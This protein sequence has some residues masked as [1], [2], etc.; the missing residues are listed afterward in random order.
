MELF[1]LIERFKRKITFLEKQKLHKQMTFFL[2]EENSQKYQ[3]ARAR[4]ET[5][6]EDVDDNLKKMAFH[7]MNPDQEKY[8]EAVRTTYYDEN[9]DIEERVSLAKAEEILEFYKRECIRAEIE[10]AG[11][12]AAQKEYVEQVKDHIFIDFN[13]DVQDAFLAFQHYGLNPNITEED[14]KVYREIVAKTHNINDS[15]YN[16]RGSAKKTGRKSVV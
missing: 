11:D 12:E 3:E 10:Y 16:S 13:E 6:E 15:N 9:E 4:I 7:I 8:Q 5:V 14:R 2:R 1:K